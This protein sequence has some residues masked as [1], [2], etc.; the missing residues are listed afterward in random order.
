MRTKA[1]DKILLTMFLRYFFFSFHF[2]F[3]LI[4]L[5]FCTSATFNSYFSFSFFVHPFFSHL[6]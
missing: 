6:F 1:L 2:R 4:L 5:Q 3:R